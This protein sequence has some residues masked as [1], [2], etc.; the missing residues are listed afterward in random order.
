[1]LLI[2]IIMNEWNSPLRG[3]N[4]ARV[5]KPDYFFRIT[6]IN[7]P[8]HTSNSDKILTTSKTRTI[9]SCSV[10]WRSGCGECGFK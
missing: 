2:K 1:M 4:G 7:S 8:N 10:G 6:C 9:S 3:I 5:I